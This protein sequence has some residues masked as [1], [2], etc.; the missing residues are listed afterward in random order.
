MLIYTYVLSDPARSSLS[1][2]NCPRQE[3]QPNF[4]IVTLCRLLEDI[5]FYGKKGDVKPRKSLESSN[6]KKS[7]AGG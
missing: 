7:S 2:V 6:T 5:G 1:Y 4:Y 3:L